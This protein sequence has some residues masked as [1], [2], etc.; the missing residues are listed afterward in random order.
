MNYLVIKEHHRKGNF[1]IRQGKQENVEIVTTNSPVIGIISSKNPETDFNF[2][3]C[4][5][6]N[7]DLIGNCIF[8]FI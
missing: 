6:H 2:N 1:E 5:Y 8:Y 3:I 7:D 4:C